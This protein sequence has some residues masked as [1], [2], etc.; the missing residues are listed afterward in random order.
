[1]A[2]AGNG[3]EQEVAAT[4]TRAFV[5]VHGAAT[6]GDDVPQQPTATELSPRALAADHAPGTAPV[7]D[8]APQGALALS[9]RALAT[10]FGAREAVEVAPGVWVVRGPCRRRALDERLRP[11][12]AH[13][14]WERSE[15]PLIRQFMLRQLHALV[16]CYAQQHVAIHTPG[17]GAERLLRPLTEDDVVRSPADVHF[18]KGEGA[19]RSGGRELMERAMQV[20]WDARAPF[21][22]TGALLLSHVYFPWPP[23][24]PFAAL[25]AAPAAYG[26]VLDALAAPQQ[27]PARYT[28]PNLPLT[29]AYF[30]ASFVE[31]LLAVPLP[32]P[33]PDDASGV[34][35]VIAGERYVRVQLLYSAKFTD[36]TGTD[37][38]AG[39][40]RHDAERG[41]VIT[42]ADQRGRERHV[43][44][45]HVITWLPLPEH[46]VDAAAATVSATPTKAPAPGG[47]LATTAQQPLQPLQLAHAPARFYS[48]AQTPLS[49]N[50][51]LLACVDASWSKGR[52]GALTAL[53]EFVRAV[54]AGRLLV[55]ISS[56]ALAEALPR[57]WPPKV[58]AR[59][60]ACGDGTSVCC[61]EAVH[62]ATHPSHP[63]TP[64]LS[65]A[66]P[67]L[68]GGCV[69][70]SGCDGGGLPRPQPGGP[71]TGGEA[72]AHAPW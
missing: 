21:D 65:C 68:A 66:P 72:A 49:P 47:R 17:P 1:M 67:N 22:G 2:T 14:R 51:Q 12:R 52:R 19:I 71:G 23:D 55:P 36:V 11:S 54:A 30:P 62:S 32:P 15:S 56:D 43:R 63:P 27:L 25:K 7:G 60:A 64:R 28:T 3:E 6:A 8:E 57:L 37:E 42:I 41:D 44:M 5:A 18:W 50:S 10:E 20:L 48:W 39:D 24:E 9:P 13:L 35:I 40:V 59:T 61:G 31:E 46:A 16:N 58:R 38:A 29:T 26:D 69:Q 70:P 53:A 33:R 4:S 45:K 34:V